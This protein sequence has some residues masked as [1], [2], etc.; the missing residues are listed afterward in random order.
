MA[1]NALYTDPVSGSGAG[2][3]ITRSRRT[4]LTVNRLNSMTQRPSVVR[5][6]PPVIV[7]A[8]TL[9]DF[10]TARAAFS[11]ARMAKGNQTISGDSRGIS[12]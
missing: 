9:H 1:V 7:L 12:A 4:I 8:P 11:R 2:D 10:R 6:A 5:R 3:V